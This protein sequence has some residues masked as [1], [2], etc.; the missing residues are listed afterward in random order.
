MWEDY[1]QPQEPPQQPPPPPEGPLKLGFDGA[2]T[3]ANVENCLRTFAAP[4]CGQVTT[5]VSLRTSS[6]KC[7]SHSMQAYSYIGMPQV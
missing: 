5:C 6:S 2:P 4:H 7:S 1:P 3:T